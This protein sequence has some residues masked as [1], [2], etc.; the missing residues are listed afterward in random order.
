MECL[1][2]QFLFYIS[3]F[4]PSF[5][6]LFKCFTIALKELPWATIITFW[7]DWIV[8][9]IV[10]FQYGKTLSIVVFKLYLIKKQITYV[11]GN[12]EG[13]TPLYFLSNLGCL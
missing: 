1:T 2:R 6:M 8:G 10:W 5:E 9:T 4:L 7:P 13:S 12:K 11:L 3:K